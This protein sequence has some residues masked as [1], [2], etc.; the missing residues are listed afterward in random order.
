MTKRIRAHE[1]E[2]ESLAAFRLLL[3]SKWLFREKSYDYGI[4]GELEIFDDEGNV[5]GLL[6]YV[7]LKSTDSKKLKD[8]L[9]GR[10]KV[11]TLDYFVKLEYPVLIAKYSSYFKKTYY[12]WAH[13]KPKKSI[14][15]DQK[16][17]TIYFLEDNILCQDSFSSIKIDV[18]NYINYKNVKLQSPFKL[19]L[20]VK[21]SNIKKSDIV[22][23]FKRH[24]SKHDTSIELCEP[25]DKE[26]I[27]RI[28]VDRE[29]LLVSIGGG[30]ATFGAHVA[31]TLDELLADVYIS[32]ALLLSVKGSFVLASRL[33]APIYKKSNFFDSHGFLVSL[34]QSFYYTY[35]YDLVLEA[36]KWSLFEKKN[37][38]DNFVFQMW[39]LRSYSKSNRKEKELLEN[40]LE[41]FIDFYRKVGDSKGLGSSY[42]NLGNFL[43]LEN[44]YRK[45]FHY[46]NKARKFNNEYVGKNYYWSEL[47]TILYNYGKIKY[48]SVAYKKSIDIGIERDIRAKYADTLIRLGDYSKALKELEKYVESDASDDELF[49]SLEA[50]ALRAIIEDFGIVDGNR[51]VESSAAL[52]S[53]NKKLT[54]TKLLSAIK[55]DPLN[56]EAWFEL[57]HDFRRRGKK[58]EAI[59]AFLWVA[60]LSDKNLEA[61]ACAIMLSID[62]ALD[63]KNNINFLASMYQVALQRNGIK[64]TEY[65][66]S[67]IDERSEMDGNSKEKIK[68]CLLEA[69]AVIKPSCSF[70]LRLFG[71]KKIIIDK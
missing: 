13:A 2:T 53:G 29:K 16:T 19:N 37:W 36:F 68:S 22:L 15:K 50:I 48:A 25:E 18:V 67:F 58:D 35:N 34:L 49:W 66:C 11:A 28:S 46:Y 5:T 4:D 32:L 55:L 61:W 30:S 54:K 65:M 44:Q 3:P 8:C 6:V 42:Y 9:K 45:A 26:T 57:A 47:G 23:Q 62:A 38:V 69:D 52:L 1:L 27:G 64:F 17:A 14:R 60:L 10:I 24:G 70:E 43:S 40:I 39:L 56:R 59:L 12:L 51:E 33:S 71:D 63:N 7:Q 41:I 21:N 31:D 20:D